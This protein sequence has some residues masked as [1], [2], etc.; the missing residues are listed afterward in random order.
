M[1]L[2]RKLVFISD[3][4]LS[5]AWFSFLLFS[6]FFVYISQICFGFGFSFLRNAWISFFCSELSLCFY[7]T[8]LL[9]FHIFFFAWN[10]FYKRIFFNYFSVC[11]SIFFI[12]YGFFFLALM[13]FLYNNILH[14]IFQ[15]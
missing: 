9:L 4:L 11:V 12:Q 14:F 15:K 2:C 13:S 6:S 5:N 3:F 10:S 1:F 8:N 7:F